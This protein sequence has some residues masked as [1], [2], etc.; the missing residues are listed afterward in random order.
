MIKEIILI[1][2]ATLNVTPMS[3]K[4]LLVQLEETDERMVTPG[5]GWGEEYRKGQ[6]KKLK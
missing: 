6:G 3:S 5:Y 1:L 4:Y 2:V